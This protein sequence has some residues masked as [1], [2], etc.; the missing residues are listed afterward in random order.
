[1][2]LIRILGAVL[3]A[4]LILA[5]GVKAQ[6][7]TAVQ[8]GRATSIRGLSVV[9]DHI[10]W[11]SG[12][13][14]NIGTSMDGG[15]T[16]A[17]QQVKGYEKL[18]FRDIEAFNASEAVIM[19]SGTPAVILKTSDGGAS[20]QEKYRNADS[21]Y[22]LDAM[23]FVD[24]KRGFIMGDPINGK[25]LI[26]ETK[27]GGETWQEMPNAPAALEGEAAFAASGTC[28]RADK[29][30]ISIVTGGSHSR[31]LSYSFEPPRV[32]L[33]RDLQILHGQ[34][35]QGAFSI[36]GPTLKVIVGGDYAKPARNDSV[37]EY[38]SYN[39]TYAGGSSLLSAT[40]PLGFQSSVEYIKGDIY[41]STGTPGSS[42]S[43]DGGKTWVRIDSK[44]YNVCRKAKNGN[45]VL[46]AGDKGKIGIY[47]P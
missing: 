17:W 36:A 13:K 40:T 34:Q 18:D 15:K 1:M 2:K 20:W 26:L 35:S 6:T 11:V 24:K 46:L 19:S 22:F 5:A 32:W 47:T 9:D 30:G 21:V 10:A 42:I 27:N 45:L 4:L 33:T 44:S 29:N 16:W 37:A 31:E 14:G 25:F 12:S 3:P 28:L 7:I 39:G 43:T 23:D 8:E 38:Y 41:V